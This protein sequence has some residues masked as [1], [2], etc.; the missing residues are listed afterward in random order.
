MEVFFRSMEKIHGGNQRFGRKR[1]AK[2]IDVAA[3][4][5]GLTDESRVDCQDVEGKLVERKNGRD[6][7]REGK[8]GL[9]KDLAPRV[10]IGR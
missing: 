8:F 3:L 6:F 9:R 5:D 2:S 10:L 4:E 1:H 7:G